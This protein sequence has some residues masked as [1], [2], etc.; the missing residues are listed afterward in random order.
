[1]LQANRSGLFEVA[2][3]LEMSQEMEEEEEKDLSAKLT[4]CSRGESD[5]NTKN[6]NQ[7]LD[8]DSSLQFLSILRD[9]LKKYTSDTGKVDQAAVTEEDR[10]MMRENFDHLTWVAQIQFK[11]GNKSPIL[12]LF[13]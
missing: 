10:M 1:M 11:F 2:N 7:I 4:T 13:S 5:D 9:L 3:P 6:P 8:H 12:R